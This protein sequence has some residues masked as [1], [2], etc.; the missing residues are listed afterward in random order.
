MTKQEEK[1][2]ELSHQA[3]EFREMDEADKEEK[4]YAKLAAEIQKA[5]NKKK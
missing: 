2:L 5:R 3:R 4:R 1:E